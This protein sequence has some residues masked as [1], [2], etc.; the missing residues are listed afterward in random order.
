[1]G[2]PVLQR[3][4]RWREIAPSGPATMG[5]RMKA[6][7]RCGRFALL[8]P[9]LMWIAASSPAFAGQRDACSGERAS[10]DQVQC[11]RV[12]YVGSDD[13]NVYAFNAST[14]ATLW[15]ADPLQCSAEG[16]PHPRLSGF[17]ARICIPLPQGKRGM[18]STAST[19]KDQR[20]CFPLPLWEREAR[21]HST[22]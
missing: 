2:Q 21:G 16:T 19:P 9:L 6:I 3:P 15:T 1:V 14:G 12:V 17:D 20:T 18:R 5:V 10:Q 7:L 11:Q 8:F 13:F 4:G 22:V